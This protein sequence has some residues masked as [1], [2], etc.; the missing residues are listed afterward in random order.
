MSIE[1][2]IQANK[3]LSSFS[4]FKIG[5]KAEYFIEV[6]S[7]EDLQEV[8]KWAKNKNQK[9]N[10]LGGGSNIVINSK[11][12]EGLVIKL[13][14]KEIFIKG[15][16]IELEAGVKLSEVL[17]E[18]IKNNLSGLEWA[19]G[20][21]GATIGGAVRGNA[22]AFSV[23][24]SDI[25]ETVE[26]LE[27]ETGKFKNF[28]NKDCKFSYRD[29][30]FKHDNNYI[31]WEVTLKLRKDNEK[32]IKDKIDK[33]LKYRNDHQPKLPSAGS[34][35][36][37]IKAE[38]LQEANSYLMQKAKELGLVKNGFIGAG[39]IIDMAGLKGKAI[40]GAKV[41]LEHANFIVNTGKA[42][43]DDIVTLISY[44]KQQVRDRFKLQLQEEIQYFGF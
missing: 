29:S 12:I 36:Q 9:V 24:M 8:L 38:K 44:I 42:T 11:G 4:T 41:S 27:M 5:G 10:I 1:S 22:G 40:G 31:I 17:R 2:K 35:F 7:K 15:E 16:R 39:W 19:I 13:S 43:S 34:V 21:P 20:I 18:A 23:E 33:N 6:K 14:N 3:D 25:V 37:N 28:S 26:V 32:K 30:I